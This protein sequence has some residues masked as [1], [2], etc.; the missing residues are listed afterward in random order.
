MISIHLFHSYDLILLQFLA[1]AALGRIYA[2]F[3]LSRLRTKL[4]KA[5]IMI[6]DLNSDTT[7]EMLVGVTTS[8][9][10]Q[11]F[12]FELA[13]DLVGNELRI[14]IKGAC[15][16]TWYDTADLKA[17][18]S[19]GVHGWVGDPKSDDLNYAETPP[20]EWF[21]GE[22]YRSALH[23]AALYTLK[24]LEIIDSSSIN[25]SQIALAVSVQHMDYAMELLKEAC[26]D[27]TY[28]D[29]RLARYGARL[30]HA[31]NEHEE[32]KYLWSVQLGMM[33]ARSAEPED[34]KRAVA[35][36]NSALQEAFD[37]TKEAVQHSADSMKKRK[38]DQTLN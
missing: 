32:A 28:N 24:V 4:E 10:K 34:L 13:T 31:G 27:T 14:H 25:F 20:W 7:T 9:P 18:A 16:Q 29:I 23:L 30:I 37:K 22:Q 15:R 36:G 1:G 33:K 12:L 17:D 2:D 5:G 6:Y 26:R 38:Q 35:A 3:R 19:D 8:V 11:R 21:E